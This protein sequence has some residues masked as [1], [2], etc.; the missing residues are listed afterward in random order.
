[1]S[2]NNESATPKKDNIFQMQAFAKQL[3]MLTM[4]K[5][6]KDEMALVRQQNSGTNGL[7]MGAHWRGNTIWRAIQ[8]VKTDFI[9]FMDE[10]TN[11]DDDDYDYDFAF[12]GNRN[13]FGHNW[14]RK[15]VSFCQGEIFS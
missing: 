12:I 7:R 5:N 10:N 9:D 2:K 11:V 8:N 6:L 1:M 3:E 13:W 15:N 14:S 4:M